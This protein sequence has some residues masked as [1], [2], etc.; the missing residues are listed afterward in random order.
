MTDDK[1]KRPLPSLDFVKPV[2]HSGPHLPVRNPAVT[3][4]MDENDPTAIPTEHLDEH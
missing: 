4:S 2:G 3:Q 1:P